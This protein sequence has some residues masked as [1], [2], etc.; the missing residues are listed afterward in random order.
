MVLSPRVTVTVCGSENTPGWSTCR[1]SVTS[2]LGFLTESV[3]SFLVHCHSTAAL[4]GGV[5]AGCQPSLN[6][7][8]MFS[9]CGSSSSCPTVYAR[10]PLS[11]PARGSREFDAVEYSPINT[12]VGPMYG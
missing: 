6:I 3:A 9:V 8:K 12:V 5:S 10:C 1:Y 4:S 2:F 11:W 7:T